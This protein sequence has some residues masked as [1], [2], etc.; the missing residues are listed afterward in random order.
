M[1]QYT[2]G[3]CEFCASKGYERRKLINS[4]A[5]LRCAMCMNVAVER[6]HFVTFQ[7]GAEQ[8]RCIHLEG[9]ARTVPHE[10]ETA[11]GEAFSIPVEPTIHI[12]RVTGARSEQWH[13][14]EG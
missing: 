7:G 12:D 6:C 5:G 8:L 14:P 9:H 3:R 2:Y 13:N 4:P 1:G 11:A 10:F